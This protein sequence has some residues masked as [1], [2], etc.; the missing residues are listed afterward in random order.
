MMSRHGLTRALSIHADYQCRHAGA[1]C[2]VGWP[3]AVDPALRTRLEAALEE[4]LLA[5]AGPPAHRRVFL[6]PA[7][8]AGA[9][10]AV[11]RAGGC[12]F[13]DQTG[14]RLCEIH[15]HLG[16]GFLPPSCRHF[17]RVALL[18]PRGV[19]ITLSH[20][21]P[22]AAGMLF[23]DVPPLAI[24]ENPAAFPAD[25]EYE[26]FDARDVLPP[27]L[28]P[29]LL[30]DLEGYSVWEREAVALL[31]REEGTPE[32]ALAALRRGAEA[33]ERWTPRGGDLSGHVRAVFAGLAAARRPPEVRSVPHARVFTRY[34]AAKLFAS[35]VPYRA[36][37]LTSLIDALDHAH[38]L[39]IGEI[40]RRSADPAHLS[41]DA[42]LESIRATDFRIVHGTSA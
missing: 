16:A 4:D 19:S 18:D 9:L 35:W 13:F 23:R 3:I 41:R 17:P 12:V 26:G 31:A 7:D 2:T 30:W 38:A 34:L 11:T 28:R 14:E 1:C 39:L 36:D 15:R 29:G 37:R 8:G 40:S 10:L 25:A 5:P 33:I 22:T 20:Y 21:C 42:L 32:R 24:V 27:L 6:E